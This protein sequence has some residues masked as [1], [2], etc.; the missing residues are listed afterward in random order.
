MKKSN[1]IGLALGMSA[2]V[3]IPVLAKP[4]G[5]TLSKPVEHHSHTSGVADSHLSACTTYY[6]KSGSTLTAVSHTT[7]AEI[8]KND[9][10]LLK[11]TSASGK[12]TSETSKITA[13][14]NPL[15]TKRTSWYSKN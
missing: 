7:Y 9:G 2:L 5:A 12:G 4:V 13:N 10:T 14:E 3:A 1:I 8:R 11:K 6:T 15:R